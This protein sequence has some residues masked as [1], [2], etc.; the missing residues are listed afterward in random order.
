MSSDDDNSSNGN[1]K[2]V[3][4]GSL[5]V[6]EYPIVLGDNPACTGCPIS[7]DWTP[8]NRYSCDI[9]LYEQFRRLGRSRRNCSGDTALSASSRRSFSVVPSGGGGSSA[10]ATRRKLILSVR[11][12]TQMLLDAGYTPEQI[13]TRTL[14]MADIRDGREESVKRSNS[15]S[16][17][18]FSK[19][20]QYHRVFGQSLSSS[21]SSSVSSSKATTTAVAN[22]NAASSPWAVAMGAQHS[23]VARSGSAGN[24]FSSKFRKSF[25]KLGAGVS[26]GSFGGGNNNKSSPRPSRK[27]IAARSA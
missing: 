22:A 2:S 23:A 26:L 21:S 25:H 27:S 1:G 4:F 18:F 17:L 16:S 5:T 6:T 13:I 24:L 8:I 3:S 19:S 12:R 15:S 14:E 9:D 7:I 20:S 10:K 11:T